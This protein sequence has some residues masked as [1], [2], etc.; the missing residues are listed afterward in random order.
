MWTNVAIVRNRQELIDA[1][2]EVDGYLLEELGRLLFLRLLTAKSIIQSA[3]NRK[4]S[5][6]AHYI[7]EK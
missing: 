5:I 4:K 1:L 7:K 6:G 2:E 3:I